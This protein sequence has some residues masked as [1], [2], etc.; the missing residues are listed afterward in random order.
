MKKFHLYELVFKIIK[1]IVIN[2]DEPNAQ[3]N[4]KKFNHTQAGDAFE[5]ELTISSKM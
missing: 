2:D 1:I 4:A 5:N 3:E